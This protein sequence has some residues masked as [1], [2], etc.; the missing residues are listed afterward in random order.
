MSTLLSIHEQE[1][2]K[3]KEEL[4]KKNEKK[5]E[6]LE[7]LI[8]LAADVS[9]KVDD[10]NK[11]IER[12][13][14]K[15]LLLGFLLISIVTTV[16]FVLYSQSPSTLFNIKIL[17]MVIISTSL[18]V[19]FFL[20]KLRSQIITAKQDLFLEELM[21]RKLLDMI[22][23]YKSSIEF[24]IVEEAIVNMRLQRIKFSTSKKNAD[25][26]LKNSQE[27]SVSISP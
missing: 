11:D 7:K 25:L 4:E 8:Q 3:K 10:L 9:A 23:P 20:I 16:F 24:S 13:Q 19:A 14:W 6:E 5:K 22:D 12:S 26:G 15:S 27:V 21:L 1:N 18:F 17:Y 2:E